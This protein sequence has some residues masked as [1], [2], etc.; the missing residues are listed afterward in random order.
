MNTSES[1]DNGVAREEWRA[2]EPLNTRFVPDNLEPP[3]ED[4]NS[5]V[6]V[7]ASH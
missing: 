4:P 1:R 7:F 5:R 6:L 2:D 3:A